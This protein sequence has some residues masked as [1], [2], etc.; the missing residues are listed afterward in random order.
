M[1]NCLYNQ[2]L[3]LKSFLLLIADGFYLLVLNML[4]LTAKVAVCVVAF[5][6]R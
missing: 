1:L 6:Y 3:P 4:K 2:R 5:L